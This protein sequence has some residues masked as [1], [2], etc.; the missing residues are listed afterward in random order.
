MND[1]VLVLAV[2]IGFPALIGI[3]G[4]INDRVIYRNWIWEKRK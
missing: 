4:V 2:C 1:T 3:V